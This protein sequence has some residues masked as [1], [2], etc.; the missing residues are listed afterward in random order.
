METFAGNS[1]LGAHRLD[2]PSGRLAWVWGGL[3]ALAL[4]TVAAAAEAKVA[5]DGFAELAQKLL[6]SVVNIS[7]TQVVEGRGGVQL[8]QL[9]PGSPFEDFF[10]K[11]FDRNRPEKRRRKA[12]SLGSGFILDNAGHVLTNNHVIEG[13]DE[14]TVILHDDTRLEAKVV[15]RDPKTDIAILKVTPSN[16][17]KPVEFGDSDVVR[18]GDWV[19]AIGNPF[20][21]G[22]TVTAGIISARGRDINAGPYDD[23][24]QTD[25]SINRGNSGGPMFNLK[26]EVI[27][28]NTAI[29]SLTGGSVGIGFAIPAAV[30]KPVVN[31]LIKHGHVRRGWLGVHIQVVS[32]EIAESLGLEKA[33][34]ALVASVIKDGP[35]EK[36]GI[37]AGDVIIEFDNKKVA[38]MRR[39]PRIV[40]KTNIEKPVSVL[41]WRDSRKVT[42]KVT[43]GELEED[44]PKVASRRGGGKDEGEHKV[45]GLGLT[46]STATKR[47]RERFKLEEDIKGV[48]VVAVDEDGPAA[49]KGIRPGD[50]VVE[51]GQ[52]EVTTPGEVLEMV[53]KTRESGRKSVLMLLEGQGGLRFV[54]LRIAQ[55]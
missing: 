24:L 41:L 51:V 38:H 29:F 36:A 32:E 14:I 2:R 11:F 49:E 43:V 19:V 15:G 52:Q 53:I 35:A 40:A 6:P 42:V 27:G 10:K 50:V 45:K 1:R 26:G 46:L 39:L 4:A 37:Q 21:L 23:F 8:P 55:G 16:G 5:P 28:I 44:Q 18:V 34:G 7:T 25:A 13:A 54:A 30:A 47:L 31:Q 22:G 12:T 17:M 20:G 48:V 9:P 33:E 3:L